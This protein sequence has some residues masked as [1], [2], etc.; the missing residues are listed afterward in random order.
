MSVPS[1]DAGW[2]ALVRAGMPPFWRLIAEGAGGRVWEREG[3]LAAIVPATPRRSFFNS[4]IYDDPE[5]MIAAI[6]DLADAY[7]QAGVEA[8]TVWVPEADTAVAAALQQ[9]GHALDATPRA[10]AMPIADLRAPDPDPALEI[11]EEPDFELVSKINEVSYGFPP[12][13][14]PALRGDH[15]EMRTYFGSIDGETVSCAGAFSHDGDCEITYV[16]VLPEGRGRGIAGRLMARALADAAEQGFETTTLQST[17]LG[18]PVYVKL[19]YRDLGEL[20]MWERR[21]PS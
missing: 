16:A 11:R 9:A 8:W 5:P 10:M 12:G 19:G 3:V 20:Q 7:E 4:V 13:D 15:P 6:D 18:Y 14:F 1:D 21:K 2:L 17:K